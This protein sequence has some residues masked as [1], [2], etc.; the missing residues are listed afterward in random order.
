MDCFPTSFYSCSYKECMIMWTLNFCPFKCAKFLLYTV[1]KVWI[2]DALIFCTF[3]YL[4]KRSYDR[5]DLAPYVE[6]LRIVDPWPMSAS[7][8]ICAIWDVKAQSMFLFWNYTCWEMDG[9]GESKIENSKNS[10][11][12]PTLIFF[13][14]ER[15]ESASYC[16]FGLRIDG[17]NHALKTFSWKNCNHEKFDGTG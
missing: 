13:S 14:W 7:Y 1:M 11:S 16:D 17:P 15:A 10:P 5:W 9:W 6:V 3:D 2:L 4:P 8:F 12:P